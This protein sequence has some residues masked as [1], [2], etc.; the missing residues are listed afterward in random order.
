MVTTY[1]ATFLRHV[2]LTPLPDAS[3]GYAT[4]T[5]KCKAA[6]TSGRFSTAQIRMPATTRAATMP[7]T[8]AARPTGPSLMATPDSRCPGDAR[9]GS[10]IGTRAI[11]SFVGML[12]GTNAPF[13]HPSQSSREP[14]VTSPWRKTTRVSPNGPDVCP[15]RSPLPPIEDGLSCGGRRTDVDRT[16]P[17]GRAS[18]TTASTPLERHGGTT[19]NESPNLRRID[20]DGRFLES[21]TVRSEE[22]SSEVERPRPHRKTTLRHSSPHDAGRRNIRRRPARSLRH[23]PIMPFCRRR[24]ASATRISELH[25]RTNGLNTRRDPTA[26]TPAPHV[27]SLGR[28]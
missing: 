18:T 11:A 12:L 3:P 26:I 17:G 8:R 21:T 2:P 9:G 24:S 4:N 15:C 20:I 1:P 7:A 28:P 14:Q 16:R 23:G 22:L 6:V 5:S 25:R 27:G 19:P 10:A 13:C